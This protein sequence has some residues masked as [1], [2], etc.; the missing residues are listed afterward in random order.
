M[1]DFPDFTRFFTEFRCSTCD[2]NFKTMKILR[3]HIERQHMERL[4]C[5]DRTFECYRCRLPFQSLADTRLHLN[6]SH[7]VVRKAKCDVCR[8][9][10]G[11]TEL[12][13]H[14]CFGM[15]TVQCEYCP[16]S[17]ETTGC[18]VAHLNHSH[19]EKQLYRCE[20]CPRFFAMAILKEHHTGQHTAV[21][22]TFACSVCPKRY[23]SKTTLLNHLKTHALKQCK[24]G[25]ALTALELAILAWSTIE[26]PPA[27]RSP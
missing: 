26:S 18:L 11:H 9:R 19:D 8:S 2:K 10:M 1:Y 25:L 21:A 6:K 20:H 13:Q 22:R 15:R 17:F 3:R 14:L 12:D 7:V 23:V 4:V 27:P 5:D 24:F 16:H